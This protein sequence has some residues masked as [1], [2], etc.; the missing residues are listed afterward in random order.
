ML[1][2]DCNLAAFALHRF[3]YKVLNS[4]YLPLSDVS[5]CLSKEKRKKNREDKMEMNHYPCGYWFNCLT[6]LNVVWD[7]VKYFLII[8]DSAISMKRV[9]KVRSSCIKWILCAAAIIQGGRKITSNF[10]LR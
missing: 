3:Q 5:V 8:R 9:N 6:G 4:K 1:S 7:K 10:I 2:H